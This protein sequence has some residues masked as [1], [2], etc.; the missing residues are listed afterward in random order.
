[1]QATFGE[2]LKEIRKTH[3][4]T[5]TQ[6]GAKLEIDSGALS[7][8]ENGKRMFDYKKLELLAHEFDIDINIL[9]NEY[10]SEKIAYEL[11]T[12]SCS[13][14]VLTLAEQKIRYYKNRKNKQLNINF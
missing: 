10:F 5:L 3:N 13:D 12:N 7:K 14:D 6:M 1:M 11:I 4:L 9:K 8:I 2:Y